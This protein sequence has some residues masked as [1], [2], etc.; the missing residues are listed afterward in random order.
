MP[1]HTETKVRIQGAPNVVK[2]MYDK[3]L[4]LV[5]DDG[6][7]KNIGFLEQ[8]VGDP[9][10]NL[11]EAELANEPSHD[12]VLKRGMPKW[13]SARLDAWGTK[14]DVYHV[15]DVHIEYIPEHAGF[16]ASAV[17]TCVW[18]TAWSPCIPAMCALSRLH[19]VDIVISYVDEGL[20]FVGR[21]TIIAGEENLRE[22]YDGYDIY[23][24]IYELWGEEHFFEWLEG[25]ASVIDADQASEVLDNFELYQAN[26]ELIE[27]IKQVLN[28]HTQPA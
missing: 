28:R 22:D 25:M 4:S 2:L 16:A 6:H 5:G 21:T 7:S 13:Y 24:G 17:L 8:F 27:R 10:K 26:T 15:C 1:N 19:D 12:N 23:R 14:W 11:S 20:F 3:L 18:D 9:V